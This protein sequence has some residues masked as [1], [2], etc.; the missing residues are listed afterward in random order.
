M[1]LSSLKD[2]E[3][4]FAARS[5]PAILILPATFDL[6]HLEG[7][8]MEIELRQLPNSMDALIVSRAV[9]STAARISSSVATAQTSVQEAENIKPFGSTADRQAYFDVSLK[10]AQQEMDNAPQRLTTAQAN[11]Q[12]QIKY[13]PRANS[14]AGQLITW[15]FIPLLGISSGFAYERRK[16][17]LRRIL[18]TPTT[19]ATFLLGTI[20][21]QVLIALVQMLLL[22]GFGILVFKLNWGHSPAALLLVM[23]ASALS[24]AALGTALGTFVKTEGQASGIS[25]TMGMTMALLG[26]CWYPLELFPAF[27][28]TVAMIFPTNWA[29][30][31]MMGIVLRGQGIMG[32]LPQVGVLMGFSLVFFVIGILRFRYE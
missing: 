32:I 16:G 10:Q 27:M 18:T 8:A 15:V 23:L 2:A 19:K 14:S 20:T 6:A 11:T 28:R 5:T 3:D 22:V 24:A 29:M 26:G 12:D 21:A 13:D 9:Q 25:L 17:T 4:A 7:G 30:Q 31:G 1:K